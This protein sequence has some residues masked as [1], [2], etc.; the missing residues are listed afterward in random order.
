MYSLIFPPSLYLDDG[1]QVP[2]FFFFL[3]S[4]PTTAGYTDGVKSSKAGYTDGVTNLKQ[5]T[6]TGLQ[7]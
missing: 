2:Y 6:Q 1:H 5:G 7:I 3:V 4:N